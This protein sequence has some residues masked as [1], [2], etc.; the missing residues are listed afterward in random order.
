[1]IQR[2]PCYAQARTLLGNILL[3]QQQY[4]QAAEQYRQALVCDPRDETASRQL[5]IALQPDL[6]KN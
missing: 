5:Q 2:E 6:I 3:A 4:P 1:M